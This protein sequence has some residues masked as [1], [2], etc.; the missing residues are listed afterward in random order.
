MAERIFVRQLEEN[1]W[2]W[3]A[4]VGDGVWEESY[5]SGDTDQLKDA[6][7]EQNAPVCLLLPGEQAVVRTMP[8]ENVDKK[9]LAKLLPYEMEDQLIDSV[10]DLHFSYGTVEGEHVNL[11][12]LDS[13]RLSAA[14]EE[15]VSGNFDIQQ[16]YPDYLLLAQQES[17]G[18]ILLDGEK[19]I[20]KFGAGKG[21]AIEVNIASMVLERLEEELAFEEVSLN[22]IADNE[23]SLKI[24]HSCLPDAWI[25]DESITINLQE[26]GYWDIVDAGLFGSSINIRS[27]NFARQLPFGKWWQAWKT[28]AYVAG[29]AFAFAFVVS[30][31]DY[32]VK[33]SEGKEIRSQIQ[34]V[35]LQAVPNGRKGDEENRLKSLL[36]GKGAKTSE[37][38]NLM[39]LLGGLASSMDQ[40]KDIKLSNFR[41]NGD[42]RELQVNMEVKGLGELAKFRELLA[43]NG[44]E[45]DSPRTTRRGEFYQANMKILEKR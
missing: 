4:M 43:S 9:H 1:L 7:Q 17:A 3:R 20:A 41:Y 19:V 30:L 29:A 38:T 14:L 44:L 33:K 45:S 34:Q 37:P 40:Q 22:L 23:E 5:Y 31:G 12:Y 13:E 6:V 26:G 35:Y 21:F 27:G 24:L 25:A 15:L 10:D 11:V 36:N 8:V 2:Q 18:T 32:F 16:I 39:L 28:S 42:Q